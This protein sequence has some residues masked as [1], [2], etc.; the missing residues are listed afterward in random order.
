MLLTKTTR[1]VINL[2]S[3]ALLT[4]SQIS[5]LLSHNYSPKHIQASEIHE[6]YSCQLQR[7]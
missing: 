7:S 1:H 4:Y 6:C 2:Q 5:S 3:N